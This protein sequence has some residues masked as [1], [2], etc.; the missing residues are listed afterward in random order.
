MTVTSSDLDTEDSDGDG[1]PNGEEA[2]RPR[3]DLPDEEVGYNMG[4]VGSTGVDPCSP[5][6]I[7]MRFYGRVGLG[8]IG[9]CHYGLPDG[10]AKQVPDVNDSGAHANVGG[11]SM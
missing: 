4:L 8:A 6:D 10:L 1:V 11:K 7:C 3:D 2:T 5:L 9:H